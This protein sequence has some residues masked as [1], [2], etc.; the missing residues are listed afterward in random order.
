MWWHAHA[1]STVL[2]PG[3]GRWQRG[4]SPESHGGGW[5]FSSSSHSICRLY[6]QVVTPT[7]CISSFLWPLAEQQFLPLGPRTHHAPSQPHR[8]TRVQ[9]VGW[10]GPPGENRRRLSRRQLPILSWAQTSP[11]LEEGPHSASS[12]TDLALVGKL[13]EEEEKQSLQVAFSP[14]QTL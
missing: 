12:L 8:Y 6:L 3:P 5:S 10:A 9:H 14:M 2:P 7:G 1:C 4:K 13:E 11:L